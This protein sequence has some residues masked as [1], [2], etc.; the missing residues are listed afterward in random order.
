MNFDAFEWHHFDWSLIWN[1]NWK[2]WFT[3]RAASFSDDDDTKNDAHT[4]AQS[5]NCDDNEK[6]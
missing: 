4:F 1:K 2:W 5:S 6:C 3:S